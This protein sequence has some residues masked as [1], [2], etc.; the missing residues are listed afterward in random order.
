V[1]TF[2]FLSAV[3]LLFSISNFAGA[4]A[5]TSMGPQY[6]TYEG[7]VTDSSNVPITTAVNFDFEILNP[8]KTCVL[9][10]ETRSMTPTNGNFAA[11]FGPGASGGTQLFPGSA[12]DL[13]AIFSNLALITGNA[14][15]YTPAGGDSRVLRVRIF[16]GAAWVTIADYDLTTAPSALVADRLGGFQPSE[17]LKIA[18]GAQT[19]VLSSA[20]VTELSNLIAGTTTQY[21]KPGS[22]SFTAAPTYSGAVSGPN[23]LTNK[24]YV[25]TS[26]STAI[27]T[28][29]GSSI[30]SGT[31]G[32]S[33][34][35]NS[36]GNITTSGVVTGGTVTGTTVQ[37]TNL[38]VYNS[39]NYFEFKS[40][41]L[42]GNLSF[43]LP[44]A[45]GTSGQV[46]KT[47]GSKNLSWVS[48]PAAGVSTVTSSNSYITIPSPTSPVLT[49]NVG[50]IA[51][52]L[53]A[54]D[55]SRIVGA[56]QK[57]GDT[58]AG[59]LDMGGYG[60]TNSGNIDI[61]T[62]KNLLLGKYSTAQETILLG[63]LA[64][65]DKGRTWFNSTSNQIKY[66]D[67]SAAQALGVSGAGLTSLNGE[68]G[69]TQTFAN[70]TSGTAPN[71]THASNVHTL[72][73]PMA[74][75]VGATAGL[76]SKTDYDAF[77]TKLDG[78]S[79]FS[80]DVSG[81]F[82]TT[83][84]DKIKGTGVSA[85]A[86]TLTTQV[87][88]FN[89]AVWAPTVLN[90]STKLPLAGGTM[91]GAIAMGG[92]NIT[93]GGAITGTA[94]T[95]TTLTST[96]A[97]GTAPLTVASTTNVPNLNASSLNGATFAAPG[98]IGSTT[99]S[100]GAFTTVTA[101]TSYVLKGAGAGAATLTYPNTGT[102][103][104]LV[105]PNTAGSSGNA[106][107]T[108]G[109][110][111]L[112]WTTPSATDPT[113]LPL[114]GGTMSG[115]IAMGGFDIT[116]TG[117]ISMAASK[118]LGLSS[119]AADPGS[120]A[121]GQMWYN[122]T[123]NTIKYYDGAI[124]T[125]GVSGA[126]LTSLNGLTGNTQT[127]ATGTAGPDF[128]ISSAGSTH[129][130]NLPSASA[131]NRG[132]LTS[133]DWATFNN[134]LD[135]TAAFGGDVSGTPT[136]ISVDKLK[137][138]P[139]TVTAP[140]AGNFLKY[141]GGAW[142]NANIT[143]AD[144]GTGVLPVIRGG[145]G[146]SS[147]VAGDLLFATSPAAMGKLG[148]G[149][150]SSVLTSSGSGPQWTTVL[151]TASGGTGVSSIPANLLLIGNA[152]GSGITSLTCGAGSVIVGS[153]TGAVQ[154]ESVNGASQLVRLDAG[155][156]I[157][158][159]GGITGSSMTLNSTS[160]GST[161]S[162]FKAI[163][164]QSANLTEW[165]SPGNSVLAS[166]DAI[167][168]MTVTALKVT[169]GTPA[170]GK[171]LTSDAV[172][173]ATWQNSAVGG[174][175]VTSIT[176]GTGLTGGTITTTGTI[177]V[178]PELAG[179]NALSTNGFIQRTAA[180]TYSSVQTNAT[181]PGD[182]GKVIKY[183]NPNWGGSFL[184]AS[185]I[186]SSTT[187]TNSAF[188]NAVCLPNQTMTYSVGTGE[189]SCSPIVITQSQISD[190]VQNSNMTLFV[191]T[192]GNDTFC[193]GSVNNSYSGNSSCAFQTLQK[194][195]DKVP[196]S[197][198]AAV[199]INVNGGTYFSGSNTL[200]TINKVFGSN[201]ALSIVGS[202]TGSTFF[203]GGSLSINT[204]LVSVRGG[205]SIGNSPSLI[206]SN[207]TFQNI[208]TEA[209]HVEGIAGFTNIN[210]NNASRGF[211]AGQGYIVIGGNVN[212]TTDSSYGATA[213]SVYGGGS[214]QIM[215][216][217]TLTINMNNPGGTTGN[218]QTGIS[219]DNGGHFSHKSTTPSTI[220]INMPFSPSVYTRGI[221][222]QNGASLEEA[223]NLN[224]Y[225]QGGANNVGIDMTGGTLNMS[226]STGNI[227]LS[228]F[229]NSGVRLQQ[230]ATIFQSN[231]AFQIDGNSPLVQMSE[232]SRLI[233]NG[234]LT[235][236]SNGTNSAMLALN[237]GSSFRYE[238]YNGGN[239]NINGGGSGAPN[240]R[241]LLLQRGSTA[242]I[243][244][245][246]NPF[247]FYSV[248]SLDYYGD[249]RTSSSL[250]FK[251]GNSGTP[252][253]LYVTSDKSSNYENTTSPQ[254]FPASSTLALTCPAGYVPV[255]TSTTAFCIS[256][257]IGTMDNLVVAT[258]N[259][260]STP[261]ADL[262]SAAQLKTA[263]LQGKSDFS[264]SY[265]WVNDI[266]LAGG[267][268][269]YQVSCS[270]GPTVNYG[271]NINTNT[272]QYYCC[273]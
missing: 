201:G 265:R 84:V 232:G 181:V 117:N 186:R 20:N 203:D 51:N 62:S 266:N 88:Q 86:P 137:G 217:T 178:A 18:A 15:T 92:N 26:I 131:T 187:P 37:A 121:V 31:I 210:I 78:S 105:L 95:G 99:A 2:K 185:D 257:I 188:M 218:G 236:N 45:D 147:Y 140:T 228:N 142:I 251:G 6:L 135:S 272:S 71:F 67:G 249:I 108:D 196:A 259:C 246:N 100:T 1:S 220:S 237:S 120:P 242:E 83:S 212:I 73:I 53:A 17:F 230:G 244:T 223:R 180:G 202:G 40:P 4:A 8:S 104:T 61:A 224:I 169:G 166:V 14:C 128:G 90:D 21:I 44:N 193:D 3:L 123:S 226:Q 149:S 46:L 151:S 262:C 107:T 39:G 116:N 89:G 96:V 184:F 177:G 33:T 11:H 199:T 66:W 253:S 97:T 229:Y 134:K 175:G 200:A 35:I 129:T 16:D 235:L 136:A 74:N 143:A 240:R 191:A 111:N 125:L 76:I 98:A 153:G 114:A 75:T 133:A 197:I 173:N 63:T 47:D 227:Y 106:L 118:T 146:L 194:A 77:N 110:G 215:D 29:S 190:L 250:T 192:F 23:D 225:G 91:S 150:S 152:G 34:A 209:A 139:L 52:T 122:S 179:L 239:F 82:S 115:A 258:S 119:N 22:A 254:I 141:S 42:G 255:T 69:S 94:I 162:V 219:L 267:S 41:V 25:D 233:S 72:N 171:V 172:G 58:M 170:P 48:Q 208:P 234:N 38:R 30:T 271:T 9:Y 132:L 264:S 68:T 261:G 156:N 164:G 256:G 207:M 80:G 5:A 231:G 216:G 238:P 49:A 12:T 103:T 127:F 93:G 245:T 101:G 268:N 145:T 174:A 19:G 138:T 263:C 113:K 55:D 273:K 56:L 87:L 24:T 148:I 32:G 13:S 124:K 130:F 270:S 252:P 221:S 109:A 157:A 126:G 79:A 222:I 214:L 112:S 144:I 57:S 65:P 213:I 247:P 102:N 198:N 248:T 243:G 183:N 50:T 269:A 64:F 205:S 260:Q 163:G 206:F 85:T 161:T 204:P 154:C 43:T 28:V 60:I 160:P 81:T 241:L 70:G 158:V 7:Y 195:L 27:S 211:S 54:G 165:R 189:F 176:A 167:G 155:S 168:T 10:D 159:S 59:A 36:S 182:N